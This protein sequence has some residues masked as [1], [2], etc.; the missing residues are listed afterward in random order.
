[1]NE[2]MDVCMF[3]LVVV[4]V[5]VLADSLLVLILPSRLVRLLLIPFIHASHSS[6][7]VF[8]IS[9]NSSSFMSCILVSP[10]LL[11]ACFLGACA[12]IHSPFRPLSVNLVQMVRVS[13]FCLVFRFETETDMS[14]SL[15]LSLSSRA[16]LPLSLS[17]E[18]DEGIRTGCGPLSTPALM[19]L[20]T[21]TSVRSTIRC[22]TSL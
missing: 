14:L 22:L 15:Y 20:C 3:Y 19:Q 18:L 21:Q 4:D 16:R 9:P 2:W 5:D 6:F 11:S 8:H 1:M 12:S 10:R 17:S 7:N 13:A